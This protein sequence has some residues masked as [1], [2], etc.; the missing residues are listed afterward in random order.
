MCFKILLCHKFASRRGPLACVFELDS[1]P[2]SHLLLCHIYLQQE[3]LQPSS[4]YG[5][6]L[7]LLHCVAELL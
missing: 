4:F 7:I 6:G 2:L 1:P 3:I 5:K